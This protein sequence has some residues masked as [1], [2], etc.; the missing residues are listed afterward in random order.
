MMQFEDVEGIVE[1]RYVCVNL[2]QDDAFLLKEPGLYCFLLRCRMSGAETFMEWTVETV[3][4]REVRK[5]GS[6]IKEKD[7]Q[8]QVLEFRNEEHQQKILRLNQEIDDL[9][10]NRHVT[11]R[12][13]FDTV[14]CFIK[15]NSG[16]GHPYYII[17]CQYKK[18]EIHKR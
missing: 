11:R 14:L 16:E 7:N 10:A 13:C 12:G 8:I 9:I 3:L 17:Q 15:K 2:P 1:R 4:P 5:L 6:A 18:L